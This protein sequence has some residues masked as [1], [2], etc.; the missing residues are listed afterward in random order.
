MDAF[1]VALP[2]FKRDMTVPFYNFCCDTARSALYS[3]SASSGLDGALGSVAVDILN[4]VG[5]EP[6]TGG[7][8]LFVAFDQFS[9]LYPLTIDVSFDKAKIIITI[10]PSIPATQSYIEVIWK[11]KSEGFT[12]AFDDFNDDPEYDAFHKIMD[13]IFIDVGV[14]DYKTLLTQCQSKYPEAQVIAKNVTTRAIFDQLI[15]APFHYFQ[16]P[17]YNRPIT[18]KRRH[19]EP[20]KI[21]AIQLLNI[22]NNDDF[23]MDEVSRIVSQD[24]ALSVSLLKLA[25]SP[26]LGMRQR[27]S[28]VKHAVVVLGQRE[29]RK[30]ATTIVTREMSYDKPNELV[31]LS[32]IRAKFAENLASQMGLTLQ[33]SNL[34]LT[35][36][37]SI[38]DIVL[39][40]TMEEAL[41]VLN[42]TTPIRNAL[43]G[44]RGPFSPVIDLIYAYEHADWFTVFRI[45]TTHDVSV[46]FLNNAFMDALRWYKILLEY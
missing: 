29:F 33:A 24:T 35:G 8:P 31:R 28:S 18:I 25:N 34:F 38:I 1:V 46:E 16:G 15:Q 9:I 41:K 7:N 17:F 21:N 2:V 26:A 23:A 32:L 6:F 19:I 44:K 37:F 5:F 3:G 20:L 22:V 30:W 42:A 12:F 27:V 45:I 10:S 14:T 13:Y 4:E 39:D 36:L 43:L 40:T 11:L